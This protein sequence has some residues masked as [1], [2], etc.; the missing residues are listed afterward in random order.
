MPSAYA[1]EVHELQHVKSFGTHG[2]RQHGID[3]V[4]VAGDNTI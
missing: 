3:M 1:S 2:H 4:G